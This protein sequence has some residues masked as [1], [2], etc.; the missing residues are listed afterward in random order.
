MRVFLVFACGIAAAIELFD[1]DTA[2]PIN[3]QTRSP[4]CA[5][6]GME[7]G[8]TLLGTS[9]HERAPMACKRLTWGFPSRLTKRALRGASRVSEH[10]AFAGWREVNEL[11]RLAHGR[12]TIAGF[13]ELWTGRWGPLLSGFC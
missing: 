11:P 2:H 8:D 9:S 12:A 6:N 4:L 1:N 5:P 10:S 13:H 3:P 7:P